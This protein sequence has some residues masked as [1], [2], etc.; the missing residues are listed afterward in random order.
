MTLQ[1]SK[2]SINEVQSAWHLA[3]QKLTSHGRTS[4]FAELAPDNI[5]QTRGFQNF[6]DMLTKYKPSLPVSNT[7][8][9]ANPYDLY[10]PLVS[11]VGLL[12][13]LYLLKANLRDLPILQLASGFAPFLEFLKTEEGVLALGID[14]DEVA[15]RYA[16]KANLHMAKA[17]ATSLPIASNT[18]SV[19]ISNHFLDPQYLSNH[20]T[21]KSPIPNIL[22]EIHRV[23]TPGGIFISNLEYVDT[24]YYSRG[25]P[26]GTADIFNEEVVTQ[27][28]FLK[29]IAIYSKAFQPIIV[30]LLTDCSTPDFKNSLIKALETLEK[31]LAKTSASPHLSKEEAQQIFNNY[32]IPTTEEIINR[33]YNLFSV[34]KLLNNQ[35]QAYDD[36]PVIETNEERAQV[37][38]KLQALEDLFY[39]EPVLLTET[40]KTLVGLSN[41]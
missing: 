11:H 26:F 33:I 3:R 18:L 12:T 29:T 35:Q 10:H 30:P 24:Y 40:I 38:L 6:Q 5:A 31:E 2:L 41:Y 32:D 8:T 36:E 21:R 27:Q 28:P 23:L 39:Y 25:F 19:V 14:I 17:C 37:L 9:Q 7:A 1:L 4:K 20:I 34:L 13:S 15:L 16:E 22:A